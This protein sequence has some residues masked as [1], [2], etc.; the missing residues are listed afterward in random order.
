[1]VCS[2]SGLDTLSAFD[3]LVKYST[4]K[5][6]KNKQSSFLLITCEFLLFL[7][8]KSVEPCDIGEPI[9]SKYTIYVR[10]RDDRGDRVGGR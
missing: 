9:R 2:P 1:M 5:R 8:V 4:G 10:G 7:C 3:K 6:K